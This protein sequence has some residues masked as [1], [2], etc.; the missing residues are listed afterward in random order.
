MH[1]PPPGP[2]VTP[3]QH[4]AT[5]LWASALSGFLSGRFGQEGGGTRGWQSS[6]PAATHPAHLCS[7]STAHLGEWKVQSCQGMVEMVLWDGALG[8]CFPRALETSPCHPAEGLGNSSLLYS[9]VRFFSS[10]LIFTTKHALKLH[11]F[12]H[13]HSSVLDL[14]VHSL[15][16]HLDVG[17]GPRSNPAHPTFEH[18]SPLTSLLDPPLLDVFCHPAVGISPCLGAVC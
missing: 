16:M 1:S 7:F 18:T 10:A 2:G 3:I 13:R 6:A 5:W 4:P 17:A 15:Q 14:M 9:S 11:V 12:W 8:W